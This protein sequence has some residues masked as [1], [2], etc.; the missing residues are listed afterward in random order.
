MGGL[1]STEN[2]DN[3]V[4]TSE[5]YDLETLIKL[6]SKLGSMN[7]N[8]YD[9]ANRPEDLH[10]AFNKNAEITNNFGYFFLPD[11][12]LDLLNK[13]LLDVSTF[14]RL[15]HGETGW[16]SE[17]LPKDS[18]AAELKVKNMEL[19]KAPYSD[20]V[21]QPLRDRLGNDLVES[22]LKGVYRA[23]SVYQFPEDTLK[24]KLPYKKVDM[25]DC[26]IGSMD[27][28]FTLFINSD[29]HFTNKLYNEWYL[30]EM[31]EPDEI[32]G[33][34]N[35]SNE[36]GGS[37]EVDSNEVDSN[38]VS[39]KETNPQTK[40]VLHIQLGDGYGVELDD[41]GNV[42]E[43]EDLRFNHL[44]D[45]ISNCKNNNTRNMKSSLSKFQKWIKN[46]QANDVYVRCGDENEGELVSMTDFLER[47]KL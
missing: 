17:I 29:D 20:D 21:L 6:K 25:S 47:L 39:S 26:T 3:S 12:N 30:Y 23:S 27:D 40:V 2:E 22:R 18:Q 28:E 24:I 13:F 46:N 8:T 41:S 9:K 7:L 36:G 37:N 5:S 16:E 14:M 31:E 4:L 32:S 10:K 42:I 19:L 11:D 44:N 1:L 15:K 35:N 34:T 38:E 33:D 45:A 43:Y